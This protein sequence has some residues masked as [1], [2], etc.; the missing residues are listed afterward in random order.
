MGRLS[1]RVA[2]VTGAARGLGRSHIARLAEDGADII[3]VDLEDPAD[4]L[5]REAIQSVQTKGREIVACQADVRDAD[6]LNDAVRTAIQRL[7]RI[8]IVVANAGSMPAAAPFLEQPPSSLK[9]AIE[10]NVFGTWHTCQATIPAMI[11]ANRGGSIV[12]IGSTL[13]FR[14]L[15]GVSAYVT[16]KHAII[17]LAKSL[18]LEF[19][20]HRIRVNSVHPTAVETPMLRSVAPPDVSYDRFKADLRALHPMPIDCLDPVDISNAVAFLASDDAE[21]ITGAALPVDAGMLLQ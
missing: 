15:S 14:A 7:G 5:F 11:D 1:G 6:A 16:S 18:A 20:S 17:G 21:F 9:H 10:T 2:F 3:A 8:D 4:A 12:L 13:S 19:G